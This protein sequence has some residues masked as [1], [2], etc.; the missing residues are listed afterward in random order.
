MLTAAGAIAYGL[1]AITFGVRYLNVI[2]HGTVVK[3]P[4][5]ITPPAAVE[6]SSSR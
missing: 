5:E 2:D 6:P 4:A 3:A 1:L